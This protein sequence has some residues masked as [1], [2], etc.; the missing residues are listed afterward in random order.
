MLDLVRSS[1]LFYMKIQYIVD[2]ILLIHITLL[3]TLLSRVARSADF[4]SCSDNVFRNFSATNSCQL[5]VS[6]SLMSQ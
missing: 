3:L 4:A 5:D 6:Y 1:R 2:I